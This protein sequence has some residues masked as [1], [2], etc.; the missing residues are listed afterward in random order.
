M[1]SQTAAGDLKPVL[2]GHPLSWLQSSTV[3]TNMVRASYVQS[4]RRAKATRLEDQPGD[5]YDKDE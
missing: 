5:G 4:S 2:G 3:S 1:M